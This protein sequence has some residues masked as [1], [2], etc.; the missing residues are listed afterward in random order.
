MKVKIGN[1]KNY[2]GPYQLTKWLPESIQ[3]KICESKFGDTLST[4]C[5]WVYSKRKRQIQVRIDDYDTWNME[6]TL[7][8]IILPMLKQ[9]KDERQ[10]STMVDYEDGPVGLKDT[11][12]EENN[13]NDINVHMRW[14]YVLDQM[15]FS[16]EHTIDDFWED[17]FHSGVIDHLWEPCD[18]GRL[19][20]LKEGPNHTHVFDKEGWEVVNQK[21]ANG[22]RL[23]GKYYTGLWD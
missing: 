22:Y 3:D 14:D 6:N 1:Y 17:E 21:I 11:G 19:S 8:H 20:E 10:G 4:L 7:A 16:F 2:I 9:L 5:N 18:E 23:F 13:W 12:T 15:I